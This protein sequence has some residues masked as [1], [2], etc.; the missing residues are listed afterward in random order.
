MVPIPEHVEAAIVRAL[1]K[2]PAD[3]YATVA[4]F[5]DA[6]AGRETVPVTPPSGQAA[7]NASAKKGCFAVLLLVTGV[8]GMAAHLL[9]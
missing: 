8:A 4:E 6:L 7:A 9:L 3:R 2:D 1:A 5:A